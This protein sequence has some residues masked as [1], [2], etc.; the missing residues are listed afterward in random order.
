MATNLNCCCCSKIS[1]FDLES[2]YL[3]KLKEIY[4]NGFQILTLCCLYFSRIAVSEEFFL[5]S[6]RSCIVPT[7]SFKSDGL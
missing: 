1:M 3:S 6:C 5:L 2:I 4:F 7:Q